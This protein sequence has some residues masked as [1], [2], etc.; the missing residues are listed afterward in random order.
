MKVR[1][2]GVW[3][4][5]WLLWHSVTLIPI[6]P[7]KTEPHASLANLAGL[8]PSGGILRKSIQ[9][10][11]LAFTASCKTDIYCAR[12]G[13]FLTQKSQ[14]AHPQPLINQTACS[15]EVAR[16]RLRVLS[17]CFAYGLMVSKSRSGRVSDN[18]FVALEKP[19]PSGR[20]VACRSKKK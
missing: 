19:L 3:P 10:P 12:F 2:S 15:Q 1:S 7:F 13:L 9:Q 11:R 18:L 4:L 5:S 17:S 8:M 20:R 6:E 16:D 14:A